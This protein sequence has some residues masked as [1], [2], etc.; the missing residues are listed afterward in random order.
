[1]RK[2]QDV[3]APMLFDVAGTKTVAPKPS[4]S[5]K[6]KE[7]EPLDLENLGLNSVYKNFEEYI[8]SRGN[9]TP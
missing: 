8:R 5:T 3:S 9:S 2:K 6:K 7:F 1:M 4:G